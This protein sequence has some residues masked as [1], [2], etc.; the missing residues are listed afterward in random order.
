[1]STGDEIVEPDR[2]PSAHQLRNSNGPML[3]GQLRELGVEGRYVGNAADTDDELNDKLRQGLASDLLLVTGGVSVGE[4]DL[5]GRALE[6]AGMEPLFHGVAMKPGKPILAGRCAGCLVVGLPGNPVSAYTGFAVL[7]APALR[8]MLGY[9]SWGNLHVDAVLQQPLRT[10]PG[11][12]TYHL[13][14]IE[15]ADGRFSGRSVSSTGSG[16]VLSMAR[17]NGFLITP[18]EAAGLEAG[19]P[20]RALLWRDAEFR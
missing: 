19:A 14:R 5:V 10:R 9:R 8:K 20:L 13:A 15:Y 18:P 7:V 6:R 4:Y 12:V 3:L 17:A 11:R 2:T 1:L 16:D